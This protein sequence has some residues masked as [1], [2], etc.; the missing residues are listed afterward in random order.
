MYR[1]AI[2]LPSWLADPS[3]CRDRLSVGQAVFLLLKTLNK[4]PEAATSCRSS[5]DES[6]S[7]LSC[8][9]RVRIS[10]A[11]LYP[12][13]GMDDHTGFRFRRCRFEVSAPLRSAQNRDPLDLVRLVGDVLKGLGVAGNIMVS[14]TV[15]ACSN[16]AAPVRL[17]SVITLA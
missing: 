7:L 17:Q 9:I 6:N 3:Y 12:R 2:I 15:V 4:R 14:K 5:M 11:M 8:H 16:R 13:G 10:S 1:D